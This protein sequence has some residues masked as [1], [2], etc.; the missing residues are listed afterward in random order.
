M[1]LSLGI[2]GN[3]YNQRTLAYVYA[4]PGK[5]I[6]NTSETTLVCEQEGSV[7]KRISESAWALHPGAIQA[8][9]ERRGSRI[10]GGQ[11]KATKYVV[12]RCVTAP[13]LPW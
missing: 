5:V 4:L 11:V 12:S 10:A 9:E 6:Y 8:A 7:Q 2:N 13:F 3:C 1:R